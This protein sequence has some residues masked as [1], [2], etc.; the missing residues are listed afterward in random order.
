[1]T[2][3]AFLTEPEPQRGVLLPVLPG[4]HRIVAAN[5]GRMTYH[6]TNTY[7]IEREDGVTVLDPGPD[8]PAHV[9][10]TIRL[11]PGPIVRILLSHT[12]RDHFGALAALK[13][14][15]GAPTVGWHRSADAAFTP[16]IPLQDGE[17][18]AGMEAVFT[19][20][21][22][23]DHLCF[24]RPDGVLFSADHVMSWSSS[25]VSPPGGNM[26]DYCRSLQRLLDRPETTYL[27]GHGPLLADAKPY[28]QALLDH[29]VARENA[30]AAAL[31]DGPMTTMALV[32][33][34][35]SKIDPIL[36]MA[37]ERNVVAHLEKLEGE[38]SVRRVG[39]AWVAA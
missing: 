33:A 29:R 19:P 23:A 12:H 2:A 31:L 37:A 5:P 27:P 8:E 14:Q 32:E 39:E 24:A 9:A 30:I 34:L 7:L 6:G 15:T 4:V 25:I 16:D 28:V 36:K 13:E 17:S 3:L 11:T 38:G 35:Y 10:D 22:A 20:G 1:M 21:H 26:A 18:V